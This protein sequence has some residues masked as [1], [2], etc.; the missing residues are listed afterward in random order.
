MVS[1][2][3]NALVAE[4]ARELGFDLIGFAKAELL[5]NEIEKYNK[6]ISAGYHSNM[7]YLK[8]GIDKRHDI[9]KVLPEA[10]SV[11]SLAMNYYSEDN[12]SG[13]I[14][15]GK[16]SR[17]A[18]GKDYHLVIWEKLA[19]LEDYLTQIN[20]EFKSRSYV[21]TGPVMDKAW[22]VR[23]GIGWLGKNTNVI[24]PD[25]GSWFF[26]ANIISN[27]EFE[28]SE[29]VSD[30]CGTCTACIDAC[31]TNAIIQPYLLDSNKCISYLTIENRSE[32]NDEFKGKFDNWIFGCDICQEVCPW[33]IR[34]ASVTE[35]RD[36]HPV[37]KEFTHSEIMQMDA[38]R[39]N[40]LFSKSPVKR[41]KLE[42]LQRN[43]KFI[44]E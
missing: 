12:Y 13:D 38:A 35:N 44:H 42:G 29:I 8:R 40:E 43:S 26:I 19:Q 9:R 16:I 27:F 20:P 6:W 22:A 25:L 24:N 32:I 39:Y 15:L 33:N 2:I 7:D 1:R 23:S 34:F 3:F 5:D 11:I 28:Y 41:A 30:H 37:R 14:S 4:K 17:Y 18:W 36:F 10:K 31:P 21:D